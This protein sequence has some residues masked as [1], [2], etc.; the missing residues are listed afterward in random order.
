M[1]GHSQ[2][3]AMEPSRGLRDSSSLGLS[4]W[5]GLGLAAL[6]QCLES[7]ADVRQTTS[8]QYRLGLAETTGADIYGHLRTVLTIPTEGEDQPR[9][10]PPPEAYTAHRANG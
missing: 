7:G 8:L 10:G 3:E 5:Q 9:G 1:T 2:A 4:V 6:A